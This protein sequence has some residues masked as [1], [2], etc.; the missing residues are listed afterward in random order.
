MSQR[1]VFITVNGNVVD[2]VFNSV[3][4]YD[5][6]VNACEDEGY[7]YDEDSDYYANVEYEWIEI[8]EGESGSDDFFDDETLLDLYK[9]NGVNGKY[10]EYEVVLIEDGEDEIPVRED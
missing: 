2:E 8:G 10:G 6:M 1:A 7:E 3:P 5:D 9:E 4:D